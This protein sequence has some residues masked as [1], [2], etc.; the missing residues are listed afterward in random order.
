MWAVGVVV[1]DVLFGGVCGDAEPVVVGAPGAL[2]ELVG[3]LDA[4]PQSVGA[5]LS[6]QEA[7]GSWGVPGL[8]TGAVRRFELQ[9]DVTVGGVGVAPGHLREVPLHRASQQTAHVSH[10][11]RAG[12]GLCQPRRGMAGTEQVAMI[13]S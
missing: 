3:F 5:G 13:R 11:D 7:A 2:P 4:V 8:G 12:C 9:A 10:D 6:D 1:P